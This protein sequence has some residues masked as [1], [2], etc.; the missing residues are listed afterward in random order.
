[1]Q[2]EAWMEIKPEPAKPFIIESGDMEVTVLGTDFNLKAYPS[3]PTR[4]SLVNGAVKASVDGKEVILKP[5]Q[6]A[7]LQNG[8]LQTGQF[9]ELETTSWRQGKYYFQQTSLKEIAA[10]IE[11]AYNLKTIFDDPTIATQTFSGM[12]NQQRPVKVFLENLHSTTAINYYFDNNGSL[13]IQ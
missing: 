4:L 9:D 2:G 7:T 5:G 10:I 3:G 1:M 13:H 12:L 8:A 6:Q 11:R